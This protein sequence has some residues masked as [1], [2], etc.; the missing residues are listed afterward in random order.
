M[1][2]GASER[3]YSLD[4]TIAGSLLLIVFLMIKVYGVAG[5][6]LTTATGLVA[7]QPLSV[8]LGTLSLYAYAFMAFVAIALLWF[9]VLG[10]R[11]INPACR[12]LAPLILVLMIM[13]ILL[14]PWRYLI[15]A[16]A[17]IAA[18]VLLGLIIYLPLGMARSRKNRGTNEDAGPERTGSP[19]PQA[20]RSGAI[21]FSEIVITIV[22]IELMA[23]VLAT[24]SKPWVPAEL[25]TLSSPI[26][27]NP[28]HPSISMTSRPV[29]FVVGDDN[30]RVTMLMDEDRY[31]MTV[32]ESMIKQR[33]ICH[34]SDQFGGAAPLIETIF[35]QPYQP[36]DLAC[37]RNT[38]Q[39]LERAKQSPP[40]WVRIMQWDS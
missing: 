27:A 1:G 7:A 25:V 32:P 10:L 11:N 20:G 17:C 12:R 38:D 3:K 33:M 24:L 14:S 21:R 31:L 36:H 28:V 23:F 16:I 2:E 22:L 9:L 29:V 5:F 26:V 40:M 15:D 18:A 8:L 39:S 19:E 30:G 4:L 34:L 6:S 37:W 13:A 35:G